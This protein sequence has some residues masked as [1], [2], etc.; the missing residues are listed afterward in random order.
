MSQTRSSVTV[1]VVLFA[2]YL[3][4]DICR[5]TKGTGLMP[6]VNTLREVGPYS[7]HTLPCFQ[8]CECPKPK[9]SLGKG[10]GKTL[11]PF[12]QALHVQ[13]PSL[14]HLLCGSVPYAMFFVVMLM[15]FMLLGAFPKSRLV[16]LYAHLAFPY[17]HL[18]FRYAAPP[19]PPHPLPPPFPLPPSFPPSHTFLP[20]FP[21]KQEVSSVARN[22]IRGASYTASWT[23][24]LGPVHQGS[25]QQPGT[26]ATDK[27]YLKSPKT[28][29][30]MGLGTNWSN[31]TRGIYTV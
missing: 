26:R 8:P 13:S 14:P 31:L 12:F 4:F 10:T 15:A 17:A 22:S 30:V 11:P 27:G 16:C 7:N 24:S 20:L 19:P 21:L 28:L 5:H 3:C 6:L 1:Y 25:L 29:L 9:P 23:R 2:L 18:I